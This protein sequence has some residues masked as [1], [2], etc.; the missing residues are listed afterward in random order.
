MKL[1]G[2]LEAGG[3]KMV[4]AIGNS[5]GEILERISIPTRTPQETIPEMISYFRQHNICSLGIGCFGPISL[6]KAAMDYGYITSTPKLAWQ[7]YPIVQ[8]FEQALQDG[9][10]DREGLTS[11]ESP[12]GF[13][14]L[15]TSPWAS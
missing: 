15:R 3:T 10:S 1:Y 11:L 14:A 4:C 12:P 13:A 7:N 9:L 5:K 8:A 2:A 6:N